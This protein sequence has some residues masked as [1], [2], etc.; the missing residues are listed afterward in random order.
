[1]QWSFQNIDHLL[2]PFAFTTCIRAS[3]K[4]YFINHFTT[5]LQVPVYAINTIHQLENKNVQVKKILQFYESY[6]V[7]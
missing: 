7:M 3:I 6:V 5:F 4:F 2:A 1:M